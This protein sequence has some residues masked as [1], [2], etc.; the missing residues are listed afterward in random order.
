LPEHF[1][2][3]AADAI[4]PDDGRG[5]LLHLREEELTPMTR[6][7]ILALAPAVLALASVAHAQPA[8]P[9]PGPRGAEMKAHFEAMQK[10]RLEDLKTILRLRPDQEPA[11]AA[12]MEAHKPEIREFKAPDGPRALTT[13]QRLEEMGKR[14]SEMTARHA[15]MRQALAR[16]YAALSP[17]QQK[18]FDALQRLEHGPGGHG[19]PGMGRHGG[20]GGP[21]IML[22]REGR[23]PD[24]GPP[25]HEPPR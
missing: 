9:P 8:G 12:F 3:G 19:G 18:V 15:Q 11:L 17:E 25:G 5:K 6:R 23:G 13:P 10:Q 20:P 22:R 21:R 24:G 1:R 14:E 4:T 16:F 2:T 7:L